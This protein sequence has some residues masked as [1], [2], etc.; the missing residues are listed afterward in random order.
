MIKLKKTLLIIIAIVF[1]GAMSYNI[2]KRF[3]EWV[4]KPEPKEYRENY[5]KVGY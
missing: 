1:V 4:H 5:K 2:Y 3:E